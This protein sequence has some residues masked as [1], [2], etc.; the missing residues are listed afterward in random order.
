MSYSPSSSSN[1]PSCSRTHVVLTLLLVELALLLGSGILV[2]LVLGD[3]IVH[4]ALSLGELH[5]VHALASVPVQ[6]SLTAEHGSEVLGHALEHL[7]NGSAVTSESNSHLQTLWRNVADAGLD[8]VRN[9]LDEVGR[10][11]VLHV[12]HLLVSLLGRHTATEE[13]S[14]SQ[15]ATVARIGGA[16]HILRIKHLLRQLRHREGAVL[17][18]A[19]GGERR[20]A[21]HE[22]VQT[23]ERNEIDSDLAKIAVQLAWEA[24]AASH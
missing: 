15:V 13:R 6:E 14:S 10:V 1:S 5:L 11:L 22:E 24:Q 21:R 9:P 7:L 16:H 17:L 20:E 2:L 12:E 3:K 23:W 4:V 19:A 18:G 8:V